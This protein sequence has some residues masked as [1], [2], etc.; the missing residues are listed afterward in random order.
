MNLIKRQY[1]VLLAVVAMLGGYAQATD[2]LE[3][4]GFETGDLTGWI[5]PSAI[6][7]VDNATLG[8]PA[9]GAQSGGTACQ[10]ALASGVAELRQSFPASPGQ[11]Y[12][13]EGW[14][15][16]EGGLPVGASFGLYKIVFQDENNNDLPPASIS[17]G[18]DN[19]DFPGVES[20]PFVN[21][22]STAGTW[23]CSKAQGV[24]PAGTT[25]VLFLALNVDF[26]DGNQNPIWYDNICASLVT[27]GSAGPNLLE[28]G[29]FETGDFT[30]WVP[31]FNPEVDNATIGAPGAGAQDG[32]FAVELALANGVAELRQTFPASP[33][34]E[35]KLDGHWLTEN[36]LPFGATFGLFKI[37]F[38]DAD[39]NDLQLDPGAIV[40][41][42][43][44]GT[45][46]PGIESVPRLDFST[47][48]DTWIFSEAQGIAPTGTTQVVFLALN[49]DFADGMQNAMWVDNICA[50][51]ITGGSAGPNML[52]N[53]S[54]ETGD[55][56]GWAPEPPSGGDGSVGAPMVGAQEGSF[57]ALL[58]NEAAV[59]ELRQSAAAAPG[60]EFRMTGYLLTEAAIPAGPSFGLFKIVFRDAAGNDLVPDSVSAGQ[61][62]GMDNPGVDSLPFV[63][64]ASA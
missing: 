16:T 8:A 25:Q 50:A 42:T 19:I 17:A 15:Q 28:N 64:D 39:G 54:F 22:D 59:G 58:T 60:D 20:L 37:V 5:D 36:L 29:D 31:E 10:L 18:Q 46:F 21:S 52:V 2:Q 40:T 12:K 11:E 6:P 27:G 38:Q 32:S 35:F 63:N 43:D 53:P 7:A 26:A 41:G 23:I 4:G 61:D 62:A 51:Q 9:S 44:A 45:D 47:N 13:L 30:G 48:V 55:F 14:L 3:N 33:G 57:A 24:A 49:I 56:T 1:I 34:D